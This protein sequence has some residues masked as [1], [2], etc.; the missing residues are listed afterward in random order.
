MINKKKFLL[1]LLSFALFISIIITVLSNYNS[2]KFKSLLV[3]YDQKYF[4]GEIENLYGLILGENWSKFFDYKTKYLPTDKFVL[5]GHG[6]GLRNTKLENSLLS[7]D[8]SR[9]KGLK[10]FELDVYFSKGKLICD[11][12]MIENNN[13]HCNLKAYF[14]KHSDELIILDIKSNFEKTLRYISR[15]NNFPNKKQLVIQLYRPSQI[16]IYKKYSNIFNS[17]I[18]TLYKTHR[19][20]SYI[21]EKLFMN[22][23]NHIVIG[24]KKLTSFMNNCPNFNFIVHPVQSCEKLNILKRQPRVVGAMVSDEALTCK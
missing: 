15:I 3:E 10:V 24:E 2:K 23:I 5:I 4:Q 11:H 22:N 12:Q 6:G 17:Y 13:I 14:S 18:F 20:N 21:C 7:F 16:D 1:I 19:K 8:F 9:K